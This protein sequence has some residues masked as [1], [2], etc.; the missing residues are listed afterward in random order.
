MKN[1][2][3]TAFV[4]QVALLTIAGLLMVV[5]THAA[6]AFITVN[7]NDD[8]FNSDGDCSLRE[9][10]QSANDNA[11]FDDCTAGS[12]IGTDAIFVAVTGGITI[13]AAIFIT[14]QVDIFG[15]GINA[16]TLDAQG[17]SQHFIVEMADDDDAFDLSGMTLANGRDSL[18]GGSIG[19]RNGGTFSFDNL[20]FDNNESSGAGGFGGAIGV[21][22][23]DGNTSSLVIS[24]CLFENN[25]SG[26]RGGALAV[27]GF[28]PFQ[29]PASL[30]ID[31]TRFS[32]NDSTDEGG[33]VYVVHTDLVEIE[34]SVFESNEADNDPGGALYIRGA[35]TSDLAFIRSSSFI[36]NR[37]SSGGAISHLHGTALVE[38][39]TFAGNQTVTS[40]GLAL[41]TRFDGVVAVL[42]STFVDHSLSR[43]IDKVIS[44]G[45]GSSLSMGH[46]IVWSDGA[47][48]DPECNVFE[49]DGTYTSLGYNIDTSGTCTGH[50][51]DLPMTDPH[52]AP[53]GDYG[54]NTTFLVQQSFLPETT[55][56]A[57]EGGKTSPCQGALGASLNVDQRGEAR[58]SITRCDIGAVEFQS[59]VDPVAY[60]LDVD[61]ASGGGEVS[62]SPGGIGCPGD[63]SEGYLS[64]TAVTLTAT[65]EAGFQFDGWS[66]DCTGTGPCAVSITSAR[67]VTASF[68]PADDEIFSSR[69]E[70]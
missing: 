17:T 22:L 66:G 37:A 7:S 52:L 32:G 8:E 46:S 40:Y 61:V 63:C 18:P 24:R 33:A 31:Q 2:N 23:P 60:T 65:P 34:R 59:G 27:D 35:N 41:N 5:S 53:L 45:D 67:S 43:E 12:S 39:A 4:R 29:A 64:G 69:F 36:D 44:I 38:N 54:D 16:L 70:N 3:R 9:A 28:P 56:P 48:P 26:D 68:V 20:R 58:P 1:D 10:I 14:E 6:A 19:L 25:R 21:R 49:G 11:S 57:I 42:H 13:S 50:A 55:G 47:E 30:T 15:P 51:N 62:S